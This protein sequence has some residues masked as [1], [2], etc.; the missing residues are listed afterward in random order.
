MNTLTKS[1]SLWAGVAI[2]AALDVVITLQV[3]DLIHHAA[4]WRCGTGSMWATTKVTFF[5]FLSL[6]IAF[7]VA[8]VYVSLRSELSPIW[9]F[10]ARLPLVCLAG[11][12]LA[13]FVVFRFL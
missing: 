3:F 13:F 7:Y 4:N 10:T 1:R 2:L 6:P 8:W 9:R 11:L 12:S 5:S